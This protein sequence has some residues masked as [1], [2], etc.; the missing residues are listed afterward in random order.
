MSSKKEPKHD[1]KGTPRTSRQFKPLD[2]KD[3]KPLSGGFVPNEQPV[4]IPQMGSI[5]IKLRDSN[6]TGEI[7]KEP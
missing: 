3:L 7:E 5:K 4:K 2:D 6:L 1:P